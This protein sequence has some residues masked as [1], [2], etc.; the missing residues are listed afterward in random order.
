MERRTLLK[1][2]GRAGGVAAVLTTMNAMGLLHSATGTER[3]KL[4]SGSGEGVKVVILGAG[5]AGMTAAYELS[6]V[7][8]DCT[9]LE[10]RDHAGGRCWT[11][12][13]QDVV[14]EF[15]TKQTCPF[16]TADYLYINAGPAR[17]PYHHKN[18]LGYCKEFGVPLQVIVNENRAAY[19]Q[20]DNAFA[21]Q[22]M[23]N[24]RVMNDS[25]GY[26]AEL[27]A[28]AINKN[29]LA[30]EI[31][32]E[33]KE[34]IL[35]FI[36][37]LGNLNKDYLYKGSS[38][39]GYTTP[40]GAG[41][42]PGTMYE[43][44]ELSEL[45]KSAF[46]RY[47]LRFA[48]GYHQ[49]ATMLQPIGGMD[50]I[51][52]AFERQVGKL[53]E[54][55]AQVSQIRKTEQGVR[56]VYTDKATGTE[57][58]LEA[59]F[60]I[61]TFPLSVLAGIDADFSPEFKN[62]I[63]IGGNSYVKAM[64]VGFQSRRFWEDDHQIYGGISWTERDI[65]QIW[66]PTSG[67]HQSKGIIVGAYIWDNDIGERWGA[68]TPAQRL[69]KAI[70]DGERIHPEYRR[71]VSPRTGVSIAWSKIPYSQG[72]WMEWESETRESVYPILN[73]SDGPLYLAGEHLSYL[74]G[75]QEGA[76]LSAHEAIR[77]IA[78]R[79]QAMKA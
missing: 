78:T 55:N 77:G 4:Q 24:R 71:E 76:I 26:I 13:G 61:C 72:G 9:I 43:P 49:A 45:L 1:L 48:E 54:Y 67:L 10:A 58:A 50:Q 68:M 52:K 65:T 34:R 75:W 59:N 22:P 70:E 8:Y 27:L 5:L 35:E 66:Y 41:L 56:V 79:L 19:F 64:K 39:A 69:N 17:I 33:D 36:S 37:A 3:P 53:I 23:L 7:G 57:K 30:Q 74:T 44:I 63:A 6:K 16:D 62:A 73:Q 28:K 29:A 51:A 21:G 12:R 46:W 40:P 32:T 25:Q 38:R 31:S 14:E 47:K 18:V 2:V 20:D 11:I 60:A 15:D 42:T